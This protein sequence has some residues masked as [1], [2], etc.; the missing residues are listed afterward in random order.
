MG[1]NIANGEQITFYSHWLP[2]LAP[3]AYT[4]NVTSSLSAKE[5][6]APGLVQETFHIDGPRYALTG[7][8]AYSC[9]PAPGQVGDF[10]DTLPHIVFDRCTLPWERTIDGTDPTHEHEPWLAL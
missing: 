1:V 2:A 10:S 7:A 5:G 8:E 9:Y 4:L 6:P 3:G